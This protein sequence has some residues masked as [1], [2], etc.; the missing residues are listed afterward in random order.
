[1]EFEGATAS[2][3]AVLQAQLAAAREAE[4]EMFQP[5]NDP[6]PQAL[7]ESDEPPGTQTTQA[8]DDAA[9]SAGTSE[10]TT[11]KPEAKAEDLRP[12]TP[13]QKA[14]T[15]EPA[16]DPAAK[17][18]SKFA[19]ENERRDTSWKALQ[20]RKAEFDKSQAEFTAQQQKFATERKDWEAKLQEQQAP[21]HTAEEY[22]AAAAHWEKQ[23]L[24]DQA[25]AARAEAKRLRTNPPKARTPTTSAVEL[26]QGQ[27]KSWQ[28]V[29]QEIPEMFDA[30]HPLN[31]EMKAWI[32]QHGATHPVMKLAEGPHLIAHFL[33]MKADVAA[34][35][36]VSS[37]VP[38]LEKE[39]VA[40]KAKITELEQ[41]VSV[42]GGGLPPGALKPRGFND[43]SEAEQEEYL[44]SQA[45]HI[46]RI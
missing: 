41:L 1:M 25:D 39:A 15:D 37:R 35:K 9:P 12:E 18:K 44:K 21:T 6:E 4:P 14:K 13:D 19:R 22:D 10:D 28:Q 45:R 29:K 30:K 40:L 2:D 5:D 46:D 3:L 7:G 24:L 33:K 32:E 17:P 36:A 27:R 16:P 31:A 43:M 11:Q 26:E 42:S 38:V 34:E 8:N 23:G 20:E